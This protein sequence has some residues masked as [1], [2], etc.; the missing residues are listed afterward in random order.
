MGRA[1]AFHAWLAV[2]SWVTAGGF[3]VGLAALLGGPVDR[4]VDYFISWLFIVPL[5]IGVGLSLGMP[6]RSPHWVRVSAAGVEIGTTRA[7]AV[8]IP[9]SGVESATVRGRSIFANL[10]LVPHPAVPPSFQDT[11]KGRAPR[12]RTRGGRRG[13]PVQ[14]GLFPGGPGAVLAALRARGVPDSR[15]PSPAVSA[16]GPAPIG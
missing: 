5:L 3:Y 10:D 15:L 12:M 1:V 9:W 13:Y 7:Q 14:A 11:K 6:L 2:F 8:L 4:M 16:S